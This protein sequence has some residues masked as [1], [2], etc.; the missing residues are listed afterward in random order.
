MSVVSALAMHLVGATVITTN[1]AG[2]ALER[3]AI[4]SSTASAWSVALSMSVYTYTGPGVV[5]QTRS[6]NGELVGP[7][8]S[9]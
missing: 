3:P 1:V 2:A 4:L 7:T 6:Y 5:Q 8:V 9:S